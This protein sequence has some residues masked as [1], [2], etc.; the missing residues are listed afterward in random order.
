VITV[1]RPNY[2]VILK[3]GWRL[4]LIAYSRKTAGDFMD[5]FRQ[6]M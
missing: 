4:S 3:N 5:R 6:A 1:V 2:N